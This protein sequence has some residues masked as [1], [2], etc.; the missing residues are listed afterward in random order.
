MLH[1]KDIIAFF[2]DSSLADAIRENDLLF[3][4]IESL[5][6]LA[7]RPRRRLDYGRRSQ[8]S[9]TCLGQASSEWRYARNLAR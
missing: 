2:E 9:R 4:L 7:I 1:F 8:A 5:H 6:V 3:P